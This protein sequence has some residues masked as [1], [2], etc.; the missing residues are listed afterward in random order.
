[1]QIDTSTDFGRRVERRLRE[2]TIIWLT[3]VTP[4]GQ[5]IPVPVWFLWEDDTALIYS[6]PDTPKLRNIEANPNVS[7]NFDS[8]GTGG[9]IVQLDGEARVDSDAPPAT[10]VAAFV[11]KYRQ[12]IAR[13]GMTP[14][15][16]A[17]A[18]SVPVR[19]AP[20]RLRGH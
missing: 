9:N 13:I 16:F 7:L 8:D 14:D 12:D 3:T 2:E 10:G 4:G 1:V 15:S 6:R 19:V 5:P 11:E 17:A 20:G 18:Y